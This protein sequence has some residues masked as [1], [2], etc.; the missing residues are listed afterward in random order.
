MVMPS[1]RMPPPRGTVADML[2]VKGTDVHGIA[3]AATVYEAVE[4]ME[5]RRVGALVVQDGDALVGIVSERDYTRKV[6]L[7]GRASRATRVD[8]IMTST[9]VTVTPATTLGE[10]LRLVSEHRIRHLPVV[11]GGK[12]VGVLSV[13][14]LV[15]AVLD[16]QAEQIE[17]LNMYIK[18]DYPN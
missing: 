18:S 10:C 16:Q 9:V 1:K 5:A 11:N 15:R 17:V 3:P 2:K 8:E 7:H 12:V 4:R 14:D 6:I 13:G